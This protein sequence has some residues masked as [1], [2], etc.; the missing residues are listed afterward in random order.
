MTQSSTY[1]KGISLLDRAADGL[2]AGGIDESLT[3]LKLAFL[4]YRSELGPRDWSQFAKD[5]F[6]QHRFKNTVHQSP[7]SYRSY[8]QPRGYAGDAVTLDYIYGLRGPGEV[9]E[10]GREIFEW[11]RATPSSAA[12]RGR[13]DLL[14]VY[15]DE[16]ARMTTRP[17]ILAVACG[18]L[19]EL[20]LSP[21][22]RDGQ[23]GEFYGLD[24][25]TES[26]SVVENEWKEMGV[27]PVAGSVRG[28]LTGKQKFSGMDFV[29]AAGL[30][31]YLQLPV[32]Q[33]LTEVMFDMLHPGGRLLV[34]NFH[35][36]LTDIASME[37]TMNWWL[38]Y[39]DEA[40]MDDVAA[41]ID[42]GKIARKRII[43]DA[44]RTLVYLELTRA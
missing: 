31:D 3:E 17:R 4:E 38:I 6:P 19:R 7:F 20:A 16:T 8:T 30:Y 26:L 35:P 44:N 15:I 11:E 13:R 41:G 18:H 33:R 32:A 34:A 14:A 37:T 9:S 2:L 40:E 12:V 42:A 25:D 23:I 1:A 10:I 28:L 24:Q 29:Y 21:A 27:Q 36:S 43:P 22:F 39:R 5:Q